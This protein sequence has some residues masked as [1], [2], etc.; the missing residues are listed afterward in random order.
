MKWEEFLL[1][2]GGDGVSR[3]VKHRE[4][5]LQEACVRWF[6]HAHADLSMLLY[7]CANEGK[8]TQAQG[9]RRRR[10]G[11]RAGVADLILQMPCGGYGSLAIEL[12]TAKGRQSVRQ[13]E[14]QRVYE[15]HGG[16][17]MVVRSVDE[18]IEVVEGYLMYNL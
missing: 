6:D 8:L 3:R 14:W 10:M 11:V 5:D 16:K 13:R 2:I 1:H 7:H 12:K 4:D 17:Y 15:A 18:F 9:A